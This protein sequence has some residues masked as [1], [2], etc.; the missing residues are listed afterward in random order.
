MSRQTSSTGT[1]VRSSHVRL[2]A[3]LHMSPACTLGSVWL[4]SDAE[5]EGSFE[6]RDV[7]VGMLS[8]VA[9]PVLEVRRQQHLIGRRRHE[10]SSGHRQITGQ[11][12][13]LGRS[14]VARSGIG[15]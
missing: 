3:V 1:W 8:G 11:A 2:T 12:Y 15:W 10:G 7:P 14:R 6:G 5:T 13:G 9:R 4:I